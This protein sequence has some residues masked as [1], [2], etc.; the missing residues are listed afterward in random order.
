MEQLLLGLDYMHGLKII[1]RDIKMENTLIG[2]SDDQLFEVKIAD[3]G[4]AIFT[5]ND[6][7]LH[8]R[9]GTPGSIAPEVLTGS[10]Y[11]Y[12]SDIFS[13]GVLFYYSLLAKT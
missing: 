2:S 7:L 13:L 4:L 12:K 9:C 10:G 3:F 6:E 8:E 11:S 1:H 5:L